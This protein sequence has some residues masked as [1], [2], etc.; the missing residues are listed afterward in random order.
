MK[1][2]REITLLS[3]TQIVK[4][5]G[6]DIAGLNCV[7]CRSVNTITNKGEN[8]WRKETGLLSIWMLGMFNPSPSVVVAIPFRPGD[9]KQFGIPPLRAT[10]TMGSYDSKNNILTLLICKLPEGK[11]EYVNSAWQIQDNHYSGDALNSC[12][13]PSFYC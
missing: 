4:Q 13:K 2:E 10:G 1:L 6:I 7:A 12:G 8:E 3:E 11:T 9:E 5:T